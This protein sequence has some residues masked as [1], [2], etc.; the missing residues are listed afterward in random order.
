MTL[1]MRQARNSTRKPSRT[2]TAL[3]A[4]LSRWVR[5]SA[6]AVRQQPITTIAVV[7]AAAQVAQVALL[8]VVAA[9]PAAV[10]ARVNRWSDLKQTRRPGRSPGLRVAS[11]SVDKSA[12]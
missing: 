1:T 6:R 9:V 3:K 12:L 11:E 4:R 8:A 2:S 10:A 7:V 5:Q